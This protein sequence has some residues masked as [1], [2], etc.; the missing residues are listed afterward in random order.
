VQGR[1]ASRNATVLSTR[2]VSSAAMPK[3]VDTSAATV[4]NRNFSYGVDTAR[5]ETSIFGFAVENFIIQNE[6]RTCR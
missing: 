6:W 1:V 4:T 2:L 3:N 5:W